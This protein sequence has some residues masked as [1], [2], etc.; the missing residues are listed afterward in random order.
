MGIPIYFK[1]RGYV[2]LDMLKIIAI[3]T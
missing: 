2:D 3:H 1:I